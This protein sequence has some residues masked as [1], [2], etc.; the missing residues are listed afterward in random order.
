M[1]TT[2]Q[3][4]AFHE[5]SSDDFE[6]YSASYLL[7]PEFMLIATPYSELWLHGPIPQHVLYLTIIRFDETI[8]LFF[9]VNTGSH[10]PLHDESTRP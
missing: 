4:I 5:H 9:Q 6:Q 1:L 10:I 7:V 2:L 8:D 3:C